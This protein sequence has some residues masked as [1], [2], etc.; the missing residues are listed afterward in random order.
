MGSKLSKLEKEIEKYRQ[1]ERTSAK[2]FKS[3]QLEARSREMKMNELVDRLLAKIEEL[4][5]EVNTSR[6]NDEKLNQELDIAKRQNFK[7][8]QMFVFNMFL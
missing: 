4:Q 2:L 1:E 7:L 6:S 8:Y 5:S 3:K